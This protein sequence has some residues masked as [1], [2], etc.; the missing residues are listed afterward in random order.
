MMVGSIVRN[1][2]YAFTGNSTGLM[3]RLQEMKKQLAKPLL[4]RFRPILCLTG[5]DR[6]GTQS[7]PAIPH[8]AELLR[9]WR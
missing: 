3:W 4:M 7:T 8:L 5:G 1:D 6:D 9:Y 2:H